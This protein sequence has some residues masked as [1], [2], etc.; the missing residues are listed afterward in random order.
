VTREL[1]R[2]G[3]QVRVV[4]RSQEKAAK[5]DADDRFISELDS[6]DA[7]ARALEGADK[8][9]FL[10]PTGLEDG[11]LLAFQKRYVNDFVKALKDSSVTHVVALSSFGAH[12]GAGSG[13]LEGLN[14][15][16]SQLAGFKG[17]LL[18]LRAGFF[19]QNFYGSIEPMK[20]QGIFTSFPI[21]DDISFYFVD[22]EDIGVAAADAL[23]TGF[24]GHKTEFLAHDTP[25]TFATV[26]T[27]LGHDLRA[28]D[29]DWLCAGWGLR[30][31]SRGIR[32][33]DHSSYR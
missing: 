7:F 23:A 15:M 12:I 14:Y 4:S 1:K 31:L 2:R 3:E 11:S 19:W 13:V 29:H 30:L 24:S 6:V 16:E 17:N 22:T 33:G 8:V 10:A 9:Y 25:Y 28:I 21:D 27:K 18:I 5:L 32:R 26:A 20:A